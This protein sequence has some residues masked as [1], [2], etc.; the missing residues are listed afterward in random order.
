M[1]LPQALEGHQEPRKSPWSHATANA[2]DN[3]AMSPLIATGAFLVAFL[4]K[5]GQAA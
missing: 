3:G 4:A 2:R 1:P 5:G